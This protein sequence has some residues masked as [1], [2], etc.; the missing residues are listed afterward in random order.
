MRPRDPRIAGLVTLALAVVL[1]MESDIG[2]GPAPSPQDTPMA[3]PSSGEPAGP[4]L[5]PVYSLPQP[6][7]FHALAARPLFVAGRR[8]PEPVAEPKPARQPKPRSARRPEFV[9]SAIVREG[10]RW[11]AVLGTQGRGAPPPDEVE[12][13][14]VVAGWAVERIGP[15][16]VELRRGTQRTALKLRSYPDPIP[17]SDNATVSNSRKGARKGE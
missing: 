11:I 6:E 9:L 4:A 5:A 12:V 2:S 8:P 7:G 3:L 15:E 1:A 17:A 13:G 16:G 10:N 14:G